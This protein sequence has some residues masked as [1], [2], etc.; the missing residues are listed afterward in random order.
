[1]YLESRAWRINMITTIIKIG[2][3]W[4]GLSVLMALLFGWM[5]SR[6]KEE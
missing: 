3:A 2:L 1:M 4:L 5:V 6:G